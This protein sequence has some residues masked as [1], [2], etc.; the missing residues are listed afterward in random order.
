MINESD[1]PTIRDV[2]NRA[3]V[4][5]STVSRVLNGLDRVSNETRNK[6]EAAIK[7]LN[8]VY[9]PVA[10]AMITKRTNIIL[11]IVPDFI[12][13]F[14]S[15]VIQGI[16][17]HLRE[18]GY[19][20]MV[21]ST[22]DVSEVDVRLLYT[23]FNSLV[24]GVIVIPSD[25]HFLEYK[26]WGKPCVVVDRY[27]HGSGMDA[28]VANNYSGAYKLTEALI[29]ANHKK[30]AIIT[31]NTKLCVCSE[32]LRGYK[33]AMTDYGLEINTDYICC[34]NMY[35]SSGETFMKK[36]LDM[37]TPPTGIVASNNLICEGCI[38]AAKELGLQIKTDISLVGFDDHLLAQVNDPGI[39]VVES[40]SISMGELAAKL[41][42]ERLNSDMTSEENREVILEVKLIE[43][44]SIRIL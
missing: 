15:R 14:F 8:F 25:E 3:N 39:T 41:L 36:L 40:P 44:D 38:T 33:S 42:L 20:A 28:V 27:I 11:V 12:N 35:Q 17:A 26:T 7:E 29:K 30:I 19:Y 34:G 1:R 31:G 32:R 18:N 2:A 21:T 13:S 37:E 16:E 22:G 9:N 10:A 43:R 5:I 6:V 4:A 23:K 24:D